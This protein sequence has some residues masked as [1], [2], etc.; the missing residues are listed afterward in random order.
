MDSKSLYDLLK[1]EKR[2]NDK[3]L[4]F[5]V[6]NIQKI[7]NDFRKIDLSKLKIIELDEYFKNK[8][9]SPHTIKNKLVSLNLY[10]DKMGVN[11]K[12][13]DDI[14]DEIVLMS[15]TINNQY[16]THHKTEKEETQ[17]ITKDEYKNMVDKYKKNIKAI[18]NYKD[19]YDV[20]IYFIGLY[21]FYYPMR[22]ELA[23]TK[24]YLLSDYKKLKDDDKKYN[25][26]IINKK[27]KNMVFVMNNYKTKNTY[28]TI[29]YE[30]NENDLYDT[31]L[32]IYNFLS[33][34][35]N[36]NLMIK[37][38]GTP[39]NRNDLT[40][41]FKQ[42]YGLSTSMLRKIFLSQMYDINKM[43]N[44]GLIMGHS[45]NTAINKYAKSDD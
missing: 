22:N 26:L 43:E 10:L 17:M 3:T 16:S 40:K 35:N 2:T 23:D 41:L 8:K 19:Y 4:K 28:G 9:Y 6:N 7:Y 20:L 44:M 45:I 14:V 13:K 42:K 30:I 32:K 5:Y 31:A 1:D 15:N 27:K 34:N 36:N 38:D 12:L 25:Y 39:F 11:N 24:I 37:I 18:N 33:K 29:E 21:H